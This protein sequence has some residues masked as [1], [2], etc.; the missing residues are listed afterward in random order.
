MTPMSLSIEIVYVNAVLDIFLNHLI[1]F[2]SFGRPYL[3][4]R[5]VVITEQKIEYKKNC[6]HIPR[7][8][9]LSY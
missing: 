6:N 3:Q 1:Q 8:Y 7:K 4:L 9:D 2:V 5:L